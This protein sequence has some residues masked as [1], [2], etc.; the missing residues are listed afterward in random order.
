MDSP[1]L[2]P[3]TVGPPQSVTILDR[4]KLILPRICVVCGR[5]SDE[6]VQ[7]TQDSVPIVL[8]GV[9]FVRTAQVAVPYCKLHAAAFRQRFANLRR[10]QTA[11]YAF[12]IIPLLAVVPPLNHIISL[13]HTMRLLACGIAVGGF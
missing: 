11:A 8:P 9:G 4:S 10:V 5:P 7:Y 13:S 1:Y 12:T 3:Q 2:A 6:L